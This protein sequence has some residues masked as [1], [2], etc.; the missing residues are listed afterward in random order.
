M[1]L[2]DR[3]DGGDFG[4]GAG[5][6]KFIH[7]VEHGAVEVLFAHGEFQFVASDFDERFSGDTAENTAG[8]WGS[9]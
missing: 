1:A 7:G 5:K 8:E 3:S 6:E 2:V 9:P 4:G